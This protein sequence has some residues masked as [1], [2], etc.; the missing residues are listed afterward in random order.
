MRSCG[1]SS[2]VSDTQPE[3]GG[4]LLS[5]CRKHSTTSPCH[6]PPA[7]DPI[8][9]LLIWGCL[10]PQSLSLAVNFSQLTFKS[11]VFVLAP[12]GLA[13]PQRRLRAVGTRITIALAEPSC[14]QAGSRQ[15]VPR[16]PAGSG[17]C[18]A[19][20]TVGGAHSRPQQQMSCPILP[21]PLLFSAGSDRKRYFSSG[22]HSGM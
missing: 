4:Y 7:P 3:L 15:W 13:S 19:T 18:C 10:R 5:S 14:P 6:S 16:S 12:V 20:I 22:N 9:P 2:G 8:C 17:P 11:H 1:V 21:R